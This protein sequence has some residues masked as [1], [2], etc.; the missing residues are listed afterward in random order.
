MSSIKCFY[1]LLSILIKT[2]SASLPCYNDY[3]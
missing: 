1:I 3:K 2:H